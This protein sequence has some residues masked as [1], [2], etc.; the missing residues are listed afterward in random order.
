VTLRFSL[1]PETSSLVLDTVSH[2]S[3]V[4]LAILLARCRSGFPADAPDVWY[5]GR[6]GAAAAAAER[7]R[8]QQAQAELRT[9]LLE[10]ARLS[11]SLTS[12]RAKLAGHEL[13]RTLSH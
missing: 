7:T 12:E 4:S 1:G 9:V 8:T 2:S 13:D 3:L 5:A 6:W 10:N 11:D